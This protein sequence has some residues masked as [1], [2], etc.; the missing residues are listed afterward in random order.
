MHRFTETEKGSQTSYSPFASAMLA[1]EFPEIE[2][3][4]AYSQT[5][6]GEVM[7]N[8][9]DRWYN[10]LFQRVVCLCRPS[11]SGL[12]NIRLINGN[13]NEINQTPDA[14]LVTEKTANRLFGT[15]DV[16][17]KTFTDINDFDD[18]QK[19]FTIRGVIE[20]FPKQSDLERYSGI[21]L[22]T[23]N[24]AICSPR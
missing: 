7:R 3:A 23:T 9:K 16:I 2:S 17:G 12:F 15:T 1:K 24:E 5:L 20:N 21:E 13:P 8:Q 4:T 22:N 11:F 14:I 19:V 18:T 10:Q 6:H